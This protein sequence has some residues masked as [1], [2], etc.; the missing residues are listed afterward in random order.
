LDQSNDTFRVLLNNSKTHLDASVGV[1][2]YGG[3]F[4]PIL[5]RGLSIP[6]QKTEVFSTA[7]D[8]QESIDIHVLQGNAN[9]VSDPK[10]TTIERF[11]L[12]GISQANAGIPQIQ[13]CFSV[14]FIGKFQINA[15]DLATGRQIE[16]AGSQ[17]ET[18]Q[19]SPVAQSMMPQESLEA[20][21]QDDCSNLPAKAPCGNWS[22]VDISGLI[23]GIV[24][25]VARTKNTPDGGLITGGLAYAICILNPAFRFNW[26]QK[27]IAT[28]IMLV[29]GLYGQQILDFVFK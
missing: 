18:P 28:I 10:V 26:V 14:N 23:A 29:V 6:C 7:A 4:T 20:K 27:S 5:E 1:E 25:A 15:K 22:M 11:S 17:P 8:S 16:V 3:T 19:K 13:V 12:K 2:T 9:N 21:P 24:F